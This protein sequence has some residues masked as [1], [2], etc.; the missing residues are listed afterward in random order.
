MILTV[1]IRKMEVKKFSQEID[2]F[3]EELRKI[4]SDKKLSIQF[5]R[6]VRSEK[7]KNKVTYF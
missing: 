3:W 2:I 7:T 5:E 1:E 6:E 4:V